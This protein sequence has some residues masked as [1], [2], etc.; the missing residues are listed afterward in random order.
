MQPSEDK[1]VTT[2]Y[3]YHLS[4]C[5]SRALQMHARDLVR[6]PPNTIYC[7]QSDDKKKKTP[8][9][10]SQKKLT[11]CSQRLAGRTAVLW[12]INEKQWSPSKGCGWWG[13][14]THILVYEIWKRT[15]DISESFLTCLINSQEKLRTLPPGKAILPFSLRGMHSWNG[16]F[17]LQRTNLWP[18]TVTPGY[19]FSLKQY[20][21][22]EAH[23]IFFSFTTLVMFPILHYYV[24]QR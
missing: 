4:Q 11:Q 15:G 13:S 16:I 24:W 18:S 9:L 19:V 7:S 6:K 1:S 10:L 3:S 8:F 14:I 17:L 23:A 20:S 21:I 12:P 22:P 2:A 5:N